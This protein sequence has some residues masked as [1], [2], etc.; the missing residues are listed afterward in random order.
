MAPYKCIYYSYSHIICVYGEWAVGDSKYEGDCKCGTAIYKENV[1][2]IDLL[3]R[4]VE[5]G[6]LDSWWVVKRM[7]F[8]AVLL[9]YFICI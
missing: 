1:I 2:I 4:S 5:S 3:Y 8:I 9:E 6:Q 7:H